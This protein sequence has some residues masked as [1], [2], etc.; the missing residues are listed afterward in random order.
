MTSLA[1]GESKPGELRSGEGAVKPFIFRRRV[2]AAAAL[3]VLLLLFFLRPGASR[4]KSRIISS[5]SAGVGRS[6][7]HRY[8]SPSTAPTAGI[9]PGKSGGI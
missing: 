1:N 2:I 7:R 5:I 4:L 8:G 9:R 6:R 3:I